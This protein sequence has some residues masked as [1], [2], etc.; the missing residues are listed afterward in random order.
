MSNPLSI[1]EKK[2][3]KFIKKF[4]TPT[5]AN[6]LEFIDPNLRYRGFTQKTMHCANPKL[7]PIVGFAKTAIITTRRK[8][9]AGINDNR[10]KYYEYMFKGEDPKIC[11]IEDKDSIDTIGAWWGEVNSQIHSQFGF[12]GAVTNGAM[13]DLDVIK[14]N[15]QILAG[16]IR[17]SHGYIQIQKI[18]CAVKIFNMKVNPNN[19]I[20]ADRHGA[21]VIKR[22]NL[23][24]LPKAIKKLLKKEK[25]NSHSKP[26]CDCDTWPAL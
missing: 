2:I 6:S 5:I 22:T 14:K 21:V 8:K 13:R 23:Q 24:K 25:A 3:V 10:E 1:K 20:H 26:S 7:E 19:L 16:E 12:E 18:D 15:F 4:D 9:N 17:P 11:V